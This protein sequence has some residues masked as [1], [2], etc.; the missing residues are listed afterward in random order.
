VARE[1]TFWALPGGRNDGPPGNGGSNENGAG[2]GNHYGWE[3]GNHYGWERGNHY[4]W[5]KADG[6]P[7]LETET[8]TYLWDG[9]SVLAEYTENGAPLAEYYSTGDRM[10][11]RKMFGL[12]DRKEPGAPNLQTHG[13]LLY[14]TFDGLGNASLLTDRTGDTVARYR[15]DAFGGLL[16]SATAPYNLYG[17][18]GKEFDPASGL[19]YFGARWYDPAVGRFTTP[20]PWPGEIRDPLTQSPYLLARANPVNFIDRWGLH[21]EDPASTYITNPNPP[22]PTADYREV[23]ARI[24]LAS[25]ECWYIV[26]VSRSAS[27]IV[28]E[29]VY[30]H[31]H[32]RQHIHLRSERTVRPDG[33]E[34][35]E[36]VTDEQWET[37]D[38]VGHH[39][40]RQVIDRIAL[41]REQIEV[42][43]GEAPGSWA[44]SAG[45]DVAES[46]LLS[47]VPI[48]GDIKDLMEAWKG[49]DE[50]TGERLTGWERVVAGVAVFVP[51]VSASA[52]RV[53]TRGGM[54]VLGVAVEAAGDAR[55]VG[56][57]ADSTKW[58]IKAF[59]ELSTGTGLQRHHILEK[60]FAETLGVNP[61]DV[62]S[63][64]LDRAEHNAVT[65]QM[66]SLLPYGS[67]YTP[68]EIMDAYVEAFGR[69]GTP[70]TEWLDAIRRYLPGE[71]TE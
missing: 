65:Q 31:L 56:L 57:A 27:A 43:A 42:L 68:Q 6:K 63:V 7:S 64:L 53:V 22:D 14:Y 58:D 28:L 24:F 70:Y 49:R 44:S 11:A 37:W 26:E 38:V 15:Y 21:A 8:T 69:P 55:L 20:D 54:E 35:W 62:P 32:L 41:K 9:L 40:D 23:W 52:V 2:Q 51:F 33:F 3:R 12:H 59:R 48:V 30:E 25:V 36:L 66:R 61:R 16:T 47:F 29:H 46:V 71:V 13:G 39:T 18:F 4:G 10:L 67:R 1:A 5:D 17:P 45:G 19:V 50:V 60:R 34:Y